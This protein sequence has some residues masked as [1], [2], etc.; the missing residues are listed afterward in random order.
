MARAIRISNRLHDDI[1]RFRS[2]HNTYEEK[3]GYDV[4]TLAA[5]NEIQILHAALSRASIAMEE[6]I[7][8]MDMAATMDRG[9]AEGMSCE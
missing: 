3:A 8:E 2:L 4:V 1:H 9:D 6:K 5:A 7:R